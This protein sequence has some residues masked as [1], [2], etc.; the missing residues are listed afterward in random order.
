L[1]G[2]DG[3]DGCDGYDGDEERTDAV[4]D[5]FRRMSLSST[6][7]F[8]GSEHP[9]DASEA[10]YFVDEWTEPNRSVTKRR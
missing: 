5:G 4:I 7:L 8:N 9:I 2:D 10:K 3:Y 6:H 1:T